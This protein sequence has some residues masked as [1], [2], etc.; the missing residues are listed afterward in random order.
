VPQF[1]LYLCR[2]RLRYQA[3][4]TGSA[5]AARQSRVSACAQSCA[6]FQIAF[7]DVTPSLRMRVLVVYAHPCVDSLLRHC[8]DA[9]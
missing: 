3:L 4:S 2:R 9:S 7:V 6:S 8:A 1:A 5:S